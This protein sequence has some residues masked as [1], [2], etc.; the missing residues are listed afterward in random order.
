VKISR[1]GMCGEKHTCGFIGVFE[2]NCLGTIGAKRFSG[3][4]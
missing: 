3:N 1:K 4:G 2:E